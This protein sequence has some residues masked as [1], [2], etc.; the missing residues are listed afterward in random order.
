MSSARLKKADGL[1]KSIERLRK[2]VSTARIKHDD[3]LVSKVMKQIVEHVDAKNA[4]IEMMAIES[5]FNADENAPLKGKQAACMALGSMHTQP[6]CFFWSTI[7]PTLSEEEMTDVIKTL[8][9]D[10][11]LRPSTFIHSFES[12]GSVT[13]CKK[14]AFLSK[15]DMKHLVIPDS[16]G[17]TVLHKHALLSDSFVEVRM[18]VRL[19]Q[20]HC[21]DEWFATCRNHAGY[22]VDDIANDAALMEESPA[23]RDCQKMME[24]T[25]RLPRCK[26]GCWLCPRHFWN[27]VR[28]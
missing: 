10:L 6:H 28:E 12:A 17:N 26:C 20:A 2:D 4:Q 13:T 21:E 14:E 3:Q 11:L 8:N 24:E 7:L 23:A 16:D 9:K 15:L 18:L 25:R 22:S 19:I 5:W 1:Q 27:D